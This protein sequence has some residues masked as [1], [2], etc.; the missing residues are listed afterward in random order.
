MTA[1]VKKQQL[2]PAELH[3]FRALH[4]ELDAAHERAAHEVTRARMQVL[5]HEVA[6]MRLSAGHNAAVRQAQAR[7]ADRE[8]DVAAAKTAALGLAEQLARD[9]A[10]DLSTHAICPTTGTITRLPGDEK[11][12]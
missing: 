11:N 7:T 5:E 3:L 1:K 4:A 6:A 10:L 8:A 9:Y 2:T 12:G